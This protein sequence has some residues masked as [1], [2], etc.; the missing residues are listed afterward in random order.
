MFESPQKSLMKLVWLG[1]YFTIRSDLRIEKEVSPREFWWSEKI[2][3]KNLQK[4]ADIVLRYAFLKLGIKVREAK[5]W[6]CSITWVV[7][8]FRAKKGFRDKLV[9]LIRLNYCSNGR[10]CRRCRRIRWRPENHITSRNWTNRKHFSPQVT[11]PIAKIFHL[12]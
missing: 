8:G 4:L 3:L 5:F 7:D 11:E 12:A 2:R 6:A 9:V 1:L 10:I